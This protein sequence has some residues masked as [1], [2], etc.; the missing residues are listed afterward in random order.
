MALGWRTQ[1]FRYKNFFLNILDVYKQKR[2]AAAFLEIILSLVTITIFTLFALK[3]TTITIIDLVKEIKGKQE[4]LKR[5][6]KKIQD[7]STARALFNDQGARIEL[8]NSTVPSQPQPEKFIRQIEGLSAFDQV[9]ILGISSGEITLVGTPKV[10]KKR[11]SIKP[12][13][14]GANEIPLSISVSGDYPNLKSFIADVESL[15]R[16]F[17]IDLLGI[18]SSQTPE[19]K[20]IVAVISGRIPYI[21]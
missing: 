19:G 14:Q 2:S 15:R 17:K 3:P 5:L 20:I 21:K 9:K 11:S 7:L 12:F 8:I 18:N 16:P 4:T 13:P 6:N 1:Y 10:K